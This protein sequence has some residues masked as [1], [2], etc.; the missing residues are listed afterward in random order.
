MTGR[1]VAIGFFMCACVF[2]QLEGRAQDRL[3][4]PTAIAAVLT[5]N[6]DVVAARAVTQE[7]AQQAPQAR[8]GFLPRLDFTQSWQRGNQPVFAFGSLLAQRQFAEADFAVQQL[9]HPDPIT[10]ARSAFSLEY[11]LF[12]GGRTR[13]SARGATLETA[14]ARAAERQARNDFVLDTTRVYGRG[15]AADAAALAAD[16]AVAAA[17]EDARIAEARRDAGT[18]SDA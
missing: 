9:N 15:L 5:A 8:A 7:A 10:N 18:A 4:L 3:P 2:L 14:V 12:D 16:S 11:A 17:E 6:P 13:A 1:N